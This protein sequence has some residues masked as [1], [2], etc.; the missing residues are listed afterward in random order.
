[1]LIKMEKT[2][3]LEAVFSLL[4]ALKLIHKGPVDE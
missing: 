4:K 1:M 2:A 3:W